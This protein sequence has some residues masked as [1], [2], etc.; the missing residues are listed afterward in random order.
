LQ[1]NNLPTLLIFSPLP[2]PNGRDALWFAA[3]R[4]CA[5]CTQKLLD[6]GADPNRTD[7]SGKTAL[8]AA[9]FTGNLASFRVLVERGAKVDVRIHTFYYLIKFTNV[10]IVN[11][12]KFGMF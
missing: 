9:A 12:F 6:L 8:F 2:S 7:E 11:T 10:R 1:C 3:E 5:E 4:G